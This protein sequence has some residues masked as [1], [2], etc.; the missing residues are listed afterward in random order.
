MRKKEEGGG[1]KKVNLILIAEAHFEENMCTYAPHF[2]LLLTAKLHF[3]EAAADLFVS[4]QRVTVKKL[5]FSSFFPSSWLCKH[6]RVKKWCF[7]PK[8]AGC[9]FVALLLP[10]R[11]IKVLGVK[12]S[13][14]EGEL[15]LL[16]KGEKENQVKRRMHAWP[17]MDSSFFTS[18]FR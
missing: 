14:G 10:L 5:T 15:D 7:L 2:F 4:T 13:E 3:V 17:N 12:I 11:A 9:F 16:L 8:A 6:K 1:G 18:L